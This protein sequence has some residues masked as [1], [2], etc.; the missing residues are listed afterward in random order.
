M[1]DILKKTIAGII[2]G[3]ALWFITQNYLLPH[4]SNSNVADTT[5]VTPQINRMESPTQPKVALTEETPDVKEAEIS[6]SADIAPQAEE[7]TKSEEKILTGGKLV[8]TVSANETHIAKQKNK[9]VEEEIA[10]I[11]RQGRAK[12]DSLVKETK[13]KNEMKQVRKKADDIFE[14]LDQ[15]VPKDTSQ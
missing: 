14:E 4:F 11:I 7:E 2:A 10:P 3:V 12:G 13:V 9:S 1:D 5:K 8:P 6:Q 15:E